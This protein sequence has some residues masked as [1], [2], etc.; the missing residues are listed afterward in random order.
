M[1]TVAFHGFLGAP[2]MWSGVAGAV[3]APWVPG[4]G[5]T[6]W[7]PPDTDFTAVVDHLADEL[8]PAEGAT[9]VGDSPGARPA[10]FLACLLYTSDAADEWR[11]VGTWRRRLS[12]DTS[13]QHA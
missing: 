13:L 8:L 12:T 6:P 11:G 1:V 2:A 10:P 4:H 3:V 9:L 5:P 7:C